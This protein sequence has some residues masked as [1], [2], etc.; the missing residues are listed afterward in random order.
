MSKSTRGVCALIAVVIIGACSPGEH[1]E[2]STDRFADLAF[3]NAKAYTLN[4]EAPWADTVLVKGD[5]IVYVGNAAGSASLI[6]ASTKLRDLAGQLLLPG[7]I[8]THV[9]PITGGAY[10]KALSLNTFGTVDEWLVAI[11]A[12]AGENPD[13]PVIFGYGFLASTFGPEG[14]SRQMIDELVPDRVVLIMDEGFHAAWANTVALKTLNITQD[15][16]DP[17]PGYSYYKRDESGDATGYLLEGTASSAMAALDVI[18]PGILV[19]GTGIIIDIMNSYGVTSVFDAGTR[20]DAELVKHVLDALES[21]GELTVR[22]VGSSRPE[23]T[24]QAATAVD[25]AEEWGR[26]IKGERYHYNTLKIPDDGTVEG[27]TAAMFED[28]QG[29]PGNS[30][31]TVFTQ[32]QMTQM[33]TDAA[34]RNI[35][36]H[37]HALG[38]RAIHESLNA[39]EVARREYPDSESRYTICHLEVMTDQDIPRFAELGVTAQSTPLWASYDVYGEQFVSEDQFNRYWRFKS[40]EDTGARLT[41]GS[42]FPASGAGTMG[43]SPVAQIEIGHTRQSAGEPDAPIQPRVSERL[44]VES[45]VRGFTIDAAYQLH[46]EDEI[47]SIE[48]GKKAD[49]MVL[50]QDIFDVDAYTIHETGVVLTMMDGKIV[51][52]AGDSSGPGL[53][54]RQSAELPQL[55][56][57]VTNN[58]VASV[59]TDDNEYLVSFA[60]LGEGRTHADTLDN[61]WVFNGSTG[62]WAEAAPLP[63]GVGRLAAAAAVVHGIAY[64]FGGYSVADDGSE[65]STP[66]VHAFDPVTGNFEERAAMPVPVDDAVAV[67]FGNRYIYLISGW[68]DVGNVNLVQRYDSQSDSWAQATPTPGSGVFGHAGGIVGNTIVYC[69]GVAIEP[70]ADRR[71]DFV[72]VDECYRGIIDLTDSRRIDW[73]TAPAHPGSPR[74][75]MAAAG[76]ATLGGVLFLGGSENPYNY[77]GIGYDGEPAEPANGALLFDLAKGEWRKLS[78]GGT[79]TMDHR[80]LVPYGPSFATIGGMRRGQRVIRTVHLYSP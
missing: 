34:S 11:A 10:A 35:D 20:G 14:P 55:P 46:M 13:I 65:V 33:I 15:T 61:T 57:P 31:E 62:E 67:A 44:S 63:G 9:H 43:L 76:D 28:Y 19:E 69:D 30:G 18:T 36:V 39:I 74:Y 27:R 26:Q 56:R 24:E 42:D 17:V 7:F 80:G 78:I 59:K 52:E 48:V 79:A 6:G 58:A 5:A 64:V 60:G 50:D 71:R 54:L 77:N 53:S 75:R 68:H 72:A 41:F 8:D 25:T 40:L 32:E 23:A 1:A 3:V 47:G 16:A 66:W 22:I 45:L 49:L 21:S 2:R 73:R 38:E 4:S 12:Y 51:Y 37:V 70:H 29:E